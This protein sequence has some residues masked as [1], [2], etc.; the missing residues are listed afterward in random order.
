MINEKILY[1]LVLVIL[2][3]SLGT[4]YYNKVEDWSY[5]D[6]FYFSTITLT[7]IGYG[8]LVPTKDSSKI[9]T[10]FYS[11]FGIGI[12]LYVIGTIISGYLIG[13]EEF[14]SSVV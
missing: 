4:G 10:S 2:M 1:A 8:D 5:V 7:T 6:S 12:M 11:I 3:L 13:K 9:F 14:F